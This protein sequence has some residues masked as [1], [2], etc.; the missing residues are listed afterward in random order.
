[1]R[2]QPRLRRRAF[3]GDLRQPR[4]RLTHF[5]G[6]RVLALHAEPEA[7]RG[8]AHADLLAVDHREDRL[9]ILAVVVE[10]DA[11][12]GARRQALEE[13]LPA[14]AAVGGLVDAAARAPFLHRV[15]GIVAILEGRL[16]AVRV[17]AVPLPL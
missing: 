9:R 13:F 14:P 10:A 2:L 15:V 1:A 6:T 16:A 3:R 8:R 12:H 11:A 4:A 17:V 5:A 7:A